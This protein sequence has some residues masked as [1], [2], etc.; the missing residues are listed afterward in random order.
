MQVLKVLLTE[1]LQDVHGQ[2]FTR[3]CTELLQIATSLQFCTPAAATFFL[4]AHNT[5]LLQT[6]ATSVQRCDATYQRCSAL[7][8]P[9]VRWASLGAGRR[10][11]SDAVSSSSIPRWGA[12]KPQDAGHRRTSQ[13]MSSTSQLFPWTLPWWHGHVMKCNETPATNIWIYLNLSESIW[14]YLNTSL[15]FLLK[16]SIHEIIQF[17]NAIKSRINLLMDSRTVLEGKALKKQ[18]G[19]ASSTFLSNSF[20]M[21]RQYGCRQNFL[22]VSSVLALIHCVLKL[23]LSLMT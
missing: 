9:R 20:E 22:H 15:Y 21:F 23:R 2:Q 3:T 12:E 1:D 18:L 7:L 10:R 5:W 19:H 8:S 4:S 17:S 11:S 6:L 16:F 14:I 13:D